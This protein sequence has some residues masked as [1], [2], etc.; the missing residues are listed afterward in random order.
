MANN[1][2][3][4]VSN[5]VPSPKKGKRSKLT[6]IGGLKS[7]WKKFI[8]VDKC[9]PPSNKHESS[10]DIADD[11]D[12]ELKGEFAQDETAMNLAA[13][14]K[15]KSMEATVK[16]TLSEGTAQVCC[17][18]PITHFYT[19]N[20]V[21]L[22]WGSLCKPRLS[23]Q[24]HCFQSKLKNQQKWP[25]WTVTFH[26]K[27][28]AV[29]SKTGSTSSYPTCVIGQGLVLLNFELCKLS[30]FMKSIWAQYNPWWPLM[31]RGQSEK[32]ELAGWISTWGIDITKLS[33][34]L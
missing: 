7:N 12:N 6:E 2:P 26:S 5:A 14:H 17:H 32:A 15:L 31:Q 13:A 23:L 30:Y 9:P 25:M 1:L 10:P 11:L 20:V 34:V 8:S 22:R 4:V 16:K 27:T 33:I 28:I 21:R 3:L 19:N 18:L 29:T 24:T